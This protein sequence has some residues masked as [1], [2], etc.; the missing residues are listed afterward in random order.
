MFEL[1]LHHLSYVIITITRHNS[2]SSPHHEIKV[3]SI[4]HPNQYFFLIDWIL[5]NGLW[6]I[7]FIPCIL[8]KHCQI[9]CC[10]SCF[11]LLT[12][13]RRKRASQMLSRFKRRDDLIF[14]SQHPDVFYAL[15]PPLHLHSWSSVMMKLPGSSCWFSASWWDSDSLRTNWPSVLHLSLQV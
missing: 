15:T 2:G 13:Y 7:L 6:H 5:F 14:L 1:N 8:L 11:R 4:L 10:H 9:K 3:K 12:L